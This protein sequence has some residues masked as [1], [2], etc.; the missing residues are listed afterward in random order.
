M[1]TRIAAVLASAFMTF[2][3]QVPAVQAGFLEDLLFAPT[4]DPSYM[5][6]TYGTPYDCATF[7]AAG[8][9]S[10][11]KGI[12]S[13]RKFDFE[14]TLVPSRAGCF[15]TRAECDAFVSYMTGF[16]DLVIYARCEPF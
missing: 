16:L 6:E 13:G 11:W 1:K 7:R 10:G 5:P 9:T 2:A 8:N 3:V 14:R 12:V 4:Y 15:Q